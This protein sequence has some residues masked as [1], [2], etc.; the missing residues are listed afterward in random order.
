MAT[1]P[2]SNQTAGVALSALNNAERP[3]GPDL[4]IPARYERR[5]RELLQWAREDEIRVNHAS[6]R[7]FRNLI[8]AT[9]V[10]GEASLTMTDA[11]DINARWGSLDGPHLAIEF[12]VDEQV[13]YA[14]AARQRG[15]GLQW[16]AGVCPI[17]DIG[18]ILARAQAAGIR[19]VW[20]SDEYP[21]ATLC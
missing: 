18:Q 17:D 10:F 8:E 13:E 5:I 21:T 12:L 2:N 9:I 4:T 6:I 3:P 1:T 7:H 20:Q 19:S 14:L 15:G 16:D 11:G